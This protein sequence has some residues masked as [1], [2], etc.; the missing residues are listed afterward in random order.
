MVKSY[1]GDG[2]SLNHLWLHHLIYNM[3]NYVFL[4]HNLPPV[5]QALINAYFGQGTGMIVLD[6]VQCSGS[7]TQLLACSSAPILTVSSNCD[8]SDDAGARCE[9]MR[10]L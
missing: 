7:E 6:D 1:H 10:K 5:G 9:G 3:F 4:N 2:N 8:H